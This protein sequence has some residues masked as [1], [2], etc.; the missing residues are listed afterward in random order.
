M[1]TLLVSPDFNIEDNHK[2]REQNYEH[3][4]NMTMKEKLTYYNTAGMNAEKEI[5]KRKASQELF[6]SS[7]NMIQLE[8][9]DRQ[10]KE[11]R[12]IVK[13]MEE[14]EQMEL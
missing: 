11:G 5:E 1:K 8:K 12:V 10:V 13:N 9:A 7:S 6:N 3:T 2:N 14:L 4:K